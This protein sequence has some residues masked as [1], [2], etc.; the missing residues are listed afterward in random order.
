MYKPAKWEI[1]AEYIATLC[2]CYTYG[3]VFFFSLWYGKST[4]DPEEF[5]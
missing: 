4:I 5:K 3:V 2:M 1:L